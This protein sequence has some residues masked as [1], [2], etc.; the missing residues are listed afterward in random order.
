ME[1]D[2]AF[3]I[4]GK[5]VEKDLIHTLGAVED[6]G[7]ENAIVIT[8][9][10]SAKHRDGEALPIAL[11]NFVN[12]SCSRHPIANDDESFAWSLSHTIALLFRNRSRGLGGQE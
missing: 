2:V 11:E 5:R 6:V 1:S 10:F 8:V 12:H 9:W 4:P 7:Q 3:G